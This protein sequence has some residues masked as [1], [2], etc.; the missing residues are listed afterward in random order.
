VP[1]D[2]K[3]TKKK[4]V[5]ELSILFNGEMVRA[6]LDGRK[7]QTRRIVNPQP[8]G[9]HSRLDFEHGILKQSSQVGGKSYQAQY[10][11]MME[12]R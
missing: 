2:K 5:P 11:G 1:T 8:D 6:I 7:V 9:R 12:L 3:R 4:E 10:I